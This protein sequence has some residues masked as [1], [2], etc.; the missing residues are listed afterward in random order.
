MLQIY[1]IINGLVFIPVD[2]LFRLR[3]NGKTQGHDKKQNILK[4]RAHKTMQEWISSPTFD[5]WL[6]QTNEQY[7]Q[8]SEIV[9]FQK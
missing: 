4:Q 1:K 3:D 6:E 5:K 2:S 7:R 8:H 9:Y